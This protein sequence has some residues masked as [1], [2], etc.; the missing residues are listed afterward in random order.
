MERRSGIAVCFICLTIFVSASSVAPVHQAGNEDCLNRHG[1]KLKAVAFL[2]VKKSFLSLRK[3]ISRVFPASLVAVL[4]DE[5]L[6]FL[7]AAASEHHFSAL[8]RGY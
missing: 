5:H 2:E 6:W 1:T 7:G 4:L 8:M 3:K